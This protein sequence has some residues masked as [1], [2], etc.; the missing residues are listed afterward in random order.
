[1]PALLLELPAIVLA[2]VSEVKAKLWVRSGES[3]GMEAHNY[4][5]PPQSMMLR[6]LDVKTLQVCNVLLA[7]SSCTAVS[8]H[9]TTTVCGPPSQF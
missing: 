7:P 4:F 8:S 2:M 9:R 5:T 6:D 1:M 3:V